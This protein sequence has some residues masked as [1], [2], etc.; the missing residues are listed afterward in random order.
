[1]R[2]SSVNYNSVLT[3]AW[4]PYELAMIVGGL[5]LLGSACLFV[6]V[7]Y[8]TQL[9]GTESKTT[10]PTTSDALPPPTVPAWLNGFAVWNYL[11]LALMVVSYGYPIAQFFFMKTYDPTA[12]GY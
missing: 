3:L 12:W 7:L 10:E 9:E 1:R 2:I 11:I 5:V 8:K 4:S 6:Y